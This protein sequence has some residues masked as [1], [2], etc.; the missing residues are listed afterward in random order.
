[1]GRSADP[2]GIEPTCRPDGR[3]G[4][5][6]WVVPDRL[7]E[8]T[9]R[10]VLGLVACGAGIALII[11]AD[12]GLAPWDV[13]HQGISERSG[14]P[15][16]TVIVIVGFSI[17]L[18]WIPLRERP[19]IG[20]VLNAILI[21]AAVDVLD[22]HLPQPEQPA[23]QFVLMGAGV[24]AFA[25]GSGLYIGAGLGPGP[26]DGLMTGLARRGLSIRTART[27]IEIVVLGAG[28]ALGGS[29]GLGTA[30]FAFGIGPL[31]QRFLPRFTMPADERQSTATPA[32]ADR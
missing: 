16:G 27:L 20:T 24:V 22:P 31:V 18:L 1:M 10:C 9:L 17:L 23:L 21:G 5:V 13:L 2:T 32:A 30:A 7:L 19:G 26:R 29:V 25:L 8:R 11:H 6:R 4:S 15:V 14:I 3:L 28:V 12:I